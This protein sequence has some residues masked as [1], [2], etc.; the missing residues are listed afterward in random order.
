MRL[1]EQDASAF[2][3]LQPDPVVL[4]VEPRVDRIGCVVWDPEVAVALLPVRWQQGEFQLAGVVAQ[5]FP[6]ELLVEADAGGGEQLDVAV[7]AYRP[8]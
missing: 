7:E 1:G 8:D 5:R 4:G 3:A 2:L 6:G